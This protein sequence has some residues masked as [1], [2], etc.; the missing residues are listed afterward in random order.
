MAWLGLYLAVEAE[1]GTNTK[2]A[3][4]TPRLLLPGP[5]LA[6]S[7]PSVPSSLAVE[8]QHEQMANTNATMEG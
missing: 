2:K 6:S 8:M 1:P 3:E 5:E 4:E 7:S